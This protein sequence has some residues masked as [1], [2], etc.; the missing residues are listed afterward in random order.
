MKLSYKD[1]VP[2]RKGEIM[3]FGNFSREYKIKSEK[4]NLSAVFK[5]EIQSD[6]KKIGRYNSNEGHLQVEAIDDLH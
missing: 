6:P 4:L 5:F 2:P 3:Q 1:R